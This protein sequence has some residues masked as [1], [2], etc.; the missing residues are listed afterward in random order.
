[1]L[2]LDEFSARITP[3]SLDI[4]ENCVELYFDDDG[5][6]LPDPAR[7]P[8]GRRRAEDYRRQATEARLNAV[9]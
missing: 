4:D 2:K 9:P 1:L 8:G 6:F 3:T 7:P 5:V